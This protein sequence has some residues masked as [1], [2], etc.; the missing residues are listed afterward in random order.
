M[1][2][3]W[4]AFIGTPRWSFVGEYG[5]TKIATFRR[6][7]C[8]KQL[9]E[10]QAGA[11]KRWLCMST[12]VKPL[13][14]KRY[15]E[16]LLN[17]QEYGDI[18]TQMQTFTTAAEQAMPTANTTAS[19]AQEPSNQT[20][21]AYTVAMCAT[22]QLQQSP[23]SYCATPSASLVSMTQPL[24]PVV[25][26]FRL[27]LDRYLVPVMTRSLLSSFDDYFSRRPILTSKVPA[28]ERG[29]GEDGQGDCSYPLYFKYEAPVLRWR[30]ITWLIYRM[31]LSSLIVFYCFAPCCKRLSL[32]RCRTW[33][34]H[35]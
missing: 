28:E 23:R 5:S 32:E 30:Y 13:L 19:V 3:C 35:A 26:L 29:R 22:P 24:T 14:N 4:F 17:S 15:S 2:R 33:V 34:G 18:H 20:A 8:C 16:K 27:W 21:D 12:A 6:F 7:Y 1:R 25:L 9:K 11:P 10:I 31:S